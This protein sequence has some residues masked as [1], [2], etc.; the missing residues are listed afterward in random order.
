MLIPFNLA[1]NLQVFLRDAGDEKAAVRRLIPGRPVG[2]L[3]LLYAIFIVSNLLIVPPRL[4]I[5]AKECLEWIATK[6]GI[7]Q[8]SLF[9]EVR[10][11]L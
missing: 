2:G 6:I 10:M 1:E 11:T 8:A 5:Y 7:A 3:L 9:A 4:Q